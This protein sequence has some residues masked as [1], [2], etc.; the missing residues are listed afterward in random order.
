MDITKK[1]NQ[2]HFN[3]IRYTDK[4]KRNCEWNC[5]VEDNCIHRTSRIH[6]KDSKLRAYDS[7]YCTGKNKGK[8]NETSDQEQALLEAKSLW[9]KQY[10]KVNAD[11]IY[12]MLAQKLNM[13]HLQFP[14]AVSRK[15]DGIRGVSVCKQNKIEITSRL[16]K[17]FSFL[18]TIRSHLQLCI[19]DDIIDGELYSH[20]IS[21]TRI[22]GAVRCK[23]KPSN[24]DPFIQYWIFDLVHTDMTYKDRIQRLKEIESDY[25]DQVPEKNRVLFFV[26]YDIAK[27][28]ED[29][30]TYHDQYVKEGFEGLMCRNLNSLYIQRHRSKDLQKY[31]NFEDKEFKIIGYKEGK[32]SEKGAIIY[33]CVC[34][35]GEFDVRPRGSISTRREMYA[36]GNEVIGKY[37]TVRYQNT[38]IQEKSELPRFPIGIDIR[39]YE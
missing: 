23:N 7:I 33:R 20:E 13:K 1:G 25:H 9:T 27:K 19:Q 26:Y 37:L 4:L 29:I 31:K 8:K 34:E 3:T 36:K 11:V 18:H 32:S 15:I 10:N 21:F 2:Y 22:S 39:D 28:E 6:S 12:P 38:G 14:I 35:E 24:D 5:W 30:Y 17:P 16:G